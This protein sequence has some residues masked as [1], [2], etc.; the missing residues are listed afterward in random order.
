MLPYISRIKLFF[1]SVSQEHC[2]IENKMWSAFSRA[3]KDIHEQR[4]EQDTDTD[5]T[6]STE[7]AIER[8]APPRL[9]EPTPIREYDIS[10]TFPRT[11]M[12]YDI[13]PYLWHVTRLRIE[14]RSQHH[15]YPERLFGGCP[16]LQHLHIGSK[17]S[18]DMFGAWLPSPL[19]QQQPFPL[20]S[21][22]LDNAYLNQEKLEEFLRFAPHLQHL[23]LSNL[24]TKG[25]SAV[26]QNRWYNCKSLVECLKGLKTPLK[27][28][29]FSV[30]QRNQR[31]TE[32]L[33]DETMF[34]MC[35]DS[36]K[37]AFGTGDITPHMLRR[38]QLLPNTITTL[39]LVNRDISF[40]KPDSKL[41]QF[42]C[43]SPQLLHLRMP[44]TAYHISYLDLYRRIPSIVVG[45]RSRAVLDAVAAQ[46]P[47]PGV[48][49]CRRLRTLH[50]AFA[51]AIP[52]GGRR[53][54]VRLEHSRVVFGYIS[55]VCPELRELY[56]HSLNYCKSN[57]FQRYELAGGFCLL[58]GLKHLERL[59]VECPVWDKVDR[60]Y[61]LDWMTAPRNSEDSKEK[62]RTIVAQWGG[63]LL[64]EKSMDSK[65]IQRKATA[66]AALASDASAAN[67]EA[68]KEE[69][70]EMLGWRYCDDKL[71]EDLN[72]VGLLLD[73]KM[74][75]ERMDSTEGFRCWP[76]LQR[77]DIG[78]FSPFG[79]VT[80]EQELQR[81]LDCS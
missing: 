30:Y 38:I 32:T 46:Y 79:L 22:V 21:L 6:D 12:V 9:F 62:R 45:D 78:S 71:K 3:L 37:W 14:H 36:R 2:R 42:L 35:P 67:R 33:V 15:I 50:V 64:A 74:M 28:F 61:D 49:A 63:K 55:K 25:R 16:Q 70:E 20:L 13:L 73:V 34:A 81:L 4:S 72:R 77:I 8:Q 51:F 7:T 53:T 52:G 68:G 54:K 17:I 56:I 57:I 58:A 10:G 1:R 31:I 47:D 19:E 18:V 24:Y 69:E 39:E 5:T 66:A 43:T 27:T 59:R 44:R 76:D 80:A 60:M 41:H 48:W 11:I 26:A 75:V 29:H 23:K 40:Y 65:R